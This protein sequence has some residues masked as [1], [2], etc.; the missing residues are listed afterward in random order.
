MSAYRL[1]VVLVKGLNTPDRRGSALAA[2]ASSC[3]AASRAAGPRFFLSSCIILKPPALPMPL[4]GGGRMVMTNAPSIL[5]SRLL[6]DARITSA[7]SPWASRSS[8]DLNTEKMAPSLEPSVSV[9]PSRPANAAGEAAPRGAGKGSLQPRC[10][11]AG[12]PHEGPGGT[13]R[14]VEGGRR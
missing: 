5:A 3:A 8:N 10:T 4:I 14:S 2:A 13:V 7:V 6:I 9:A 1:G 11:A 12:L